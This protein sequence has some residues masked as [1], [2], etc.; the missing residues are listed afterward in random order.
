MGQYPQQYMARFLTNRTADAGFQNL[1]DLR[2]HAPNPRSDVRA[3]GAFSR[4]AEWSSATD[5]VSTR[6]PAFDCELPS[7]INARPVSVVSWD[8]ILSAVFSWS[9]PL[10]HRSRGRDFSTAGILS[11]FAVARIATVFSIA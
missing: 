8:G 10:C 11:D 5:T 3:V 2:D 4:Q 6:F 9:R 1:A 7:I